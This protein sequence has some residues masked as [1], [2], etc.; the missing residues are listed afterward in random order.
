MANDNLKRLVKYQEKI[1]EQ[2]TADTPSKHK[3]RK[4]SYRTFLLN[5]LDTTTKKIESYKL[6]DK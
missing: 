2:L 6:G 1:K 3:S 4:D 5:E